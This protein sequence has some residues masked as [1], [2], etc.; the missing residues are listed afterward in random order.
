[1]KKIKIGLFFIVLIFLG[2]IVYLNNEY[3]LTPY[4]LVIDLKIK[5]WQWELAPIMNIG[6]FGIF[7]CSGFLVAAYMWLSSSF[8]ARKVIKQLNRDI[9]AYHEQIQ[10]LKTE[11]DKFNN[12]PYINSKPESEGEKS[13]EQAQST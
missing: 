4:P 13:P 3:F 12:D 1:M 10:S 7:F 5:S 11:L 8:R 2:W 6:Y 9:N